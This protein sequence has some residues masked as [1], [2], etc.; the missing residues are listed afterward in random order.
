MSN[1]LSMLEVCHEEMTQFSELFDTGATRTILKNNGFSS[2]SGD[3][4]T[5]YARETTSDRIPQSSTTHK[6]WGSQNITKLSVAKRD[7]FL[8]SMTIY[9]YAS[10]GAQ[11]PSHSGFVITP[12]AFWN[13]RNGLDTVWLEF[14]LTDE[15]H[16]I[17]SDFPEDQH[18]Q[19]SLLTD[20]PDRDILQKTYEAG[21]KISGK[22][23]ISTTVHD[24]SPNKT[25]VDVT[26]I[27]KELKSFIDHLRGLV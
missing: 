25:G 11:V 4:R 14:D 20:L 17:P 3:G 8:I 27:H 2:G 6:L 9:D 10:M 23:S 12:I 16:I 26:L 18:F 21:T 15:K 7:S 22:C 24:Y 5:Y 1:L 19:L 13:Y